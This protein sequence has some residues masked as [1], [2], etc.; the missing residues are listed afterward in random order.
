M[1]L[2]SKQF[3]DK[4]Q[5]GDRVLISVNLRGSILLL[6]GI[7]SHKNG[8]ASYIDTFM[9]ITGVRSPDGNRTFA[10]FRRK[11]IVSV[12]SDPSINSGY[13]INLKI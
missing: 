3:L 11:D 2:R 9:N 12:E 10:Q 5:P 6:D 7:L 4:M 13:V 8:N 1:N